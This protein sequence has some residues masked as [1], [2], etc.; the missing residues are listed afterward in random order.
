M[1]CSIIIR[2]ILIG[3]IFSMLILIYQTGHQLTVIGMDS[4]ESKTL[5]MRYFKYSSF[6]TIGM[7]VT[8]VFIFDPI[9]KIEPHAP[10]KAPGVPMK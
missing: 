4:P 1:K 7:L 10:T 5:L 9:T 3:L 6:V 8:A 2:I